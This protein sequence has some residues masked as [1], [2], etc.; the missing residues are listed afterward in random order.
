MS[1]AIIIEGIRFQARCGVTPDERQCPQP[2]LADLELTC[3]VE[4]AIHSDSLTKTVDYAR[5][6]Q[7]VIDVGTTHENALIERLANQI[8]QILMMEFPIQR[9]TIWLRKA[10]P[11][12]PDV[13]GS[14]GI[15]LTYPRTRAIESVSPFQPSPFLHAVAH[16]IPKGK[17]LDVAAGEGRH[18]L[19]MAS[20]GYDVIGLDRDERALA[21]MTRTAKDHH[22][23]NLSTWNVDL[24]K[25][26]ETPPSLGDQAYDGILVFFY[27]FRPLFPSILQALKPG[28]VLI[29]ETFLIDNHLR[30]NHPRRKDFCLEQNELLHLT[31]PLRVLR[32]EESPH[33]SPLHHEPAITARLV[34]Q[35]P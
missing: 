23:S 29:Y 25:D 1:E 14:V 16:V 17:V 28:G 32:Y 2:L 22:L 31:H 20:Q 7:R 15:R 6:M 24:E 10:A 11:P 34:A 27:L 3:S 30:F 13:S 12:L 26:P 33:P 21:T 9:L 18:A 8:A 4:D 35:K 5:V 19:Y